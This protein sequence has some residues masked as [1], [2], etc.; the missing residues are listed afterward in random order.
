MA[1]IMEKA[2]ERVRCP[3]CSSTM[4]RCSSG[5]CIHCDN[6]ACVY[7]SRLSTVAKPRTVTP[8]ADPVIGL[9]FRNTITG[10][11]LRTLCM[12]R[13][14]TQAAFMRLY[15]VRCHRSNPGKSSFANNF[16][17]FVRFTRNDIGTWVEYA[18]RPYGCIRKGDTLEWALTE[19]RLESPTGTME[20]RMRDIVRSMPMDKLQGAEMFLENY[21]TTSTFHAASDEPE[22]IA[23]LQVVRS[24]IAG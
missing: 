23:W 11:M 21:L 16:G 8:T 19:R 5:D 24:V 22:T 3:K 15:H 14:M 20:D 6:E 17:R 10:A 12:Q 1:T 2:I 13:E 18:K 7:T 4:H 9:M